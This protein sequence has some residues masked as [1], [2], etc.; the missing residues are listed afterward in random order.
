LKLGILIVEL[1]L[2][3]VVGDLIM[4]SSGGI[5]SRRDS[6][7]WRLPAVHGGNVTENKNNFGREKE[8]GKAQREYGLVG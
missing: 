5:V 1:V 8:N 2:E 3:G 4:D 6:S 7:V